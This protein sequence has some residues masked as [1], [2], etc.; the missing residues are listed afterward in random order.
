MHTPAIKLLRWLTYLGNK[1]GVIPLHFDN[2]NE[3]FK[4]VD[5]TDQKRRSKFW[6]RIIFLGWVLKV[7]DIFHFMKYSSIMPVFA[8]LYQGFTLM[9]LFGQTTYF[10]IG[11]LNAD[12][13]CILLNILQKYP[14]GVVKLNYVTQKRRN[15][16]VCS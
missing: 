12:R 16:I 2:L 7:V 10:T 4:F 13:V 9:S 5:T 15:M 8:F 11:N 3:G 6:K 1:T 14:D